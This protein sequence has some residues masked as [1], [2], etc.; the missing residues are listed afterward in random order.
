MNDKIKS[1]IASLALA[2]TMAM[3]PG[4]SAEIETEK[5]EDVMQ[6]EY[7][8]YLMNVK[9]D[10]LS[11]YDVDFVDFF[12]N[13]KIIINGESY[14]VESLYLL[15]CQKNDVRKVMVLCNDNIEYDILSGESYKGYKKLS[16]RKFRDSE[17]FFNLYQIFKNTINDNMLIIDNVFYQ[18][19]INIIYQFNDTLHEETPETKHGKGRY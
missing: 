17:T 13:G 19:F 18:E 7:Y 10:D 5:H 16:M 14:L 3:T 9:N 15:E 1:R 2:G 8:E 12:R 11:V 4:A 6:R